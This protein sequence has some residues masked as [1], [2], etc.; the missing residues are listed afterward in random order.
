MPE[1]EREPEKPDVPPPP[2]RQPDESLKGYIER[3][4][5]A[6]PPRPPAED[7]TSSR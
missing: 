2:P 5:R 3:G 4:N 6:L 7:R 1:Q